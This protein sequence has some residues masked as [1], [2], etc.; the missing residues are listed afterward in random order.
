MSDFFVAETN[1][2][3][4]VLFNAGELSDEPVTDADMVHVT[5]HGDEMKAARSAAWSSGAWWYFFC[6]DAGLLL[7]SVDTH[8]GVLCKKKSYKFIEAFLQ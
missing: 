5:A 8:R 7:M 6:L 1:N 4:F 3:S 2:K